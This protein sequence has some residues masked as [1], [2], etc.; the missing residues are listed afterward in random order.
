MNLER[1]KPCTGTS[2]TVAED[3]P[4]PQTQ[5]TDASVNKS[6]SFKERPVEVCLR[7][8]NFETIQKCV[9]ET[10]CSKDCMQW[11]LLPPATEAMKQKASLAKGRFVGDPS[12]EFEHVEIKKTGS[13]EEQEEEE[14]LVTKTTFREIPKS[15]L[16][17]TFVRNERKLH[18]AESWE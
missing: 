10:F 2:V 7:E 12:Y 4:F 11:G 16:I 3:D 5:T 14:E 15:D 18:A 9:F 1:G 6:C 17:W 8:N 13:G